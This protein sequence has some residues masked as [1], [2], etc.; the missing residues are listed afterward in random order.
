MMAGAR[1]AQDVPPRYRV[2]RSF[3][4]AGD[5]VYEPGEIIEADASWPWHRAQDLTTQRYLL[6]LTREDAPAAGG[7]GGRR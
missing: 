2:V 5:R 1:T 6:P 7:K 4:G 3:R